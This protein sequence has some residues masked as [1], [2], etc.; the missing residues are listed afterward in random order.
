MLVYGLYRC[1]TL[2]GTLIY[3]PGHHIAET[4]QSGMQ[5]ARLV[6]FG[7]MMPWHIDESTEERKTAIQSVNKHLSNR[8]NGAIDRKRGGAKPGALFEMEI[9]SGGEFFGEVVVENYTL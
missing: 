3:M 6:R 1:F 9:L 8:T 4:D 2:F 7:D 5:H